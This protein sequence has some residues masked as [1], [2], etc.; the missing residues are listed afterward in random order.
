MKPQLLFAPQSAPPT[1]RT[2]HDCDMAHMTSLFQGRGLFGQEIESRFQEDMPTPRSEKR[3]PAFTDPE[4][5]W[6]AADAQA[7]ASDAVPAA[8]RES[9]ARGEFTLANKDLLARLDTVDWSS[10]EE[11]D[12]NDH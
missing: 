11:D 12:V 3:K 5:M 1:A 10:D 2:V 7:S 4:A 9:R 8:V 6:L